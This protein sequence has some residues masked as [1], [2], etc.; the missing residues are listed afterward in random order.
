MAES[1]SLLG[2]QRTTLRMQAV[3]ALRHAIAS[4][5]LA[6]GSHV[7]E[8]EMAGR[9]Q[10]SRGTL[11][12]AMRTLQLE[13]LLTE[14]GRGR[15]MVRQMS[16]QELRDLFQVRAA[17][18]ALAART[19]AVRADREEPV[20]RLT[21]MANRMAGVPES[22]EHR[23]RADLDFHLEMCRLTGNETLVRAWTALE[24]S[25]QMS[26]THSGLDRAIENMNVARHLAL[27]DAIATGDPDAAAAAVREHMDAAA[28]V[29]IS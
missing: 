6:Q 24:G 9:L 25:I 28:H 23:M 22:L 5:E 17:L 26:I 12:E 20:A 19:L 11:R 2:L 7:S 3:E 18:E 13:G 8:I 14:G 4:G 15:L 10:I 27:V 1:P 21:E 16:E 29:L